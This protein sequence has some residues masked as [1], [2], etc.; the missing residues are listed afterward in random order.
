MA[1]DNGTGALREEPLPL[2]SAV[3]PLASRGA[4]VFTQGRGRRV[5]SWW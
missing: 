1:W 2:L 5:Q 4:Q 3:F